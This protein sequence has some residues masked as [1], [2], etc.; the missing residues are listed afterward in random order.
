MCQSVQKKGCVQH[1]LPD[2]LI[3]GLLHRQVEGVPQQADEHVDV[4]AGELAAVVVG[5]L[6]DD[7]LHQAGD[8][9]DTPAF[10]ADN[11]E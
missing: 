8:D 7:G 4:V 9:T 5:R 6:L 2:T 1:S 10:L 11:L 3:H